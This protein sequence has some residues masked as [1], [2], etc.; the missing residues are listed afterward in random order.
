MAHN[1]IVLI[2]QSRKD[3][4]QP[5]TDELDKSSLQ[6]LLEQHS[7]R[8]DG[9]V[10]F[11]TTSLALSEMNTSIVNLNSQYIVK[12]DM[13]FF[14]C[15]IPSLGYELC[16]SDGDDALA[17]FRLCVGNGP[18]NPQHFTIIDDRLVGLVDHPTE[19]VN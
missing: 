15:G 4:Y 14:Q 18:S 17:T 9:L 11:N 16:I 1:Y 10:S 19:E 12:D 8:L 3:D 5:S 13:L 7:L 6:P 2:L